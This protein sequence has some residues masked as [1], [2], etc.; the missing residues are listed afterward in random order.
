MMQQFGECDHSTL[1]QAISAGTWNNGHLLAMI[2]ISIIS[3]AWWIIKNIKTIWY[4]N[5]SS[6]YPYGS[7]RWKA[8]SAPKK[9]YPK[10]FLRRYSDPVWFHGTFGIGFC[11]IHSPWPLWD[12]QHV[13]S[14][15]QEPWV[16]IR[17]HVEEMGRKKP[18]DSIGSKWF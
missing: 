4:Q 10:C 17:K 2:F 16:M 14:K 7:K 15:G 1:S 9:S 11:R 12:V 18:V 8:T 5:Y 3:A 6:R 13:G